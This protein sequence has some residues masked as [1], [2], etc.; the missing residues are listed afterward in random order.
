MVDDPNRFSCFVDSIIA[1]LLIMKVDQLCDQPLPEPYVHIPM[2]TARYP[3]RLLLLKVVLFLFCF[4]FLG[5]EE[6]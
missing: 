4:D 1:V 6:I 2:H 3:I 5:L